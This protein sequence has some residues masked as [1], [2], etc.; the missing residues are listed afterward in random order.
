[1]LEQRQHF[2]VKQAMDEVIYDLA[3]DLV[4]SRK[5]N[6]ELFDLLQDSSETL[7]LAGKKP[8]VVQRMTKRL[9]QWQASVEVSLSG[10]DY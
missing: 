9:R 3:D 10:A 8:R 6:V 5:G 1:M 2:A 7:N 4:L